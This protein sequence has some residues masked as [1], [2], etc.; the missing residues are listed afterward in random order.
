MLVSQVIVVILS[1][2]GVAWC[3]YRPVYFL[4][5]LI[6][7]VP[8][9]IS[10]TWFPHLRALETLSAFLGVI[11][12]A[13]IFSLAFLAYVAWSLIRRHLYGRVREEAS[14]TLRGSSFE[15]G[16]LW[17]DELSWVNIVL[18]L[19][20]GAYILLGFSSVL[21]SVNRTKTLVEAIRLTVL[22]SLGFAS[23]YTL[24]RHKAFGLIPLSFAIISSGL[25]ILGVSELITKNFLWLGDVYAVSGRINGTF[26]DANIFARYLVIGILATFVLILSGVERRSFLLGLLALFLQT[27]ALLGTGS[28]TGWLAAALVLL[29]LWLILPQRRLGFILLSLA[30]I[31]VIGTLLHPEILGRIKDLGK[32]LAFAS[33][34]RQFLVR[35]GWAM[36]VTHPLWGVGLGGFQT[37]MFTHY[38]DL[39]HNQ[40]SL[41][42][43]ALLTT[44]AELGILGV[45]IILVFFFFLYSG[46]PQLRDR[47]K[48]APVM[49]GYRRIVMYTVFAVLSMTVIFISAQGE[50]RF[51]EDPLLWILL[52][53]WSALSHV[54]GVG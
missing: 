31:A 13:R 12:L 40:I 20:L 11:D 48:I 28:R 23:Y 26:V 39:I 14:F 25:A 16:L 8:L 5:A 46:I 41:S 35:A 38:S 32:G 45:A 29:A 27:A 52:G 18:F 36:F 21:W 19:V 10:R 37:V 33:T 17:M 49:S 47:E 7:V 51:L 15:A 44:A 1:L 9:E 54:E 43:T 53:Y 4:P 3:W 22:W 2:L 24:L 6:A 42:H 34:E 50:G 30:G